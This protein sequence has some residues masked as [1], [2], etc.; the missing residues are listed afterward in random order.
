MSE[1]KDLATM[2]GARIP[3]V[4]IKSHDDQRIM[5]LLLHFA[6]KCSLTFCKWLVTHGLELGGFET[7]LEND[8]N[9]TDPAALLSN[10]EPAYTHRGTSMPETD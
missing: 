1:T 2:L 10:P 5:A 6:M 8:E 9:L 3:I 7:A 4:V